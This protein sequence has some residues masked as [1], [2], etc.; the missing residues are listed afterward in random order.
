MSGGACA[1][2]DVVA[3]TGASGYVGSAAAR[4][5]G[6]EV[7]RI[8]RPAWVLG[9][10]PELDGVDAI[11]HCA[12]DF[13]A[14]TRAEIGRIN[15]DGSRRLIDAASAAGTRVVFVSTLSAFPGCRSLYGQAKLA[16]EEHVAVAG[17]VSVRPG[18]V[19]GEPGGSLYAALRRLALA[20]PV[21]P[22]FTGEAR[23][24]KLVHEDDLGPSIAAL[25]RVDAGGGPYVAAS[26]DALSLG[27]ILRAIAAAHARSVRIAHIPWRAAWA[28][29]R[30]L[31][32]LGFSPPFRSDS[33]LSL[34]SLDQSPLEHAE[35]A[36]G[37]FRPFAPA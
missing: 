13:G 18:L 3:V 23:K 8:T 1:S 7:V 31:E 35:Q 9:D 17:G 20:L 12:W 30:A 11:V 16:V 10:V 36:P 26:D 4:H 24:V 22:V 37:A 29:L 14:R 25:A 27:A 2:P 34:V 15:V 21:L 19:W 28:P 6:P 5:L 33:V 32:L